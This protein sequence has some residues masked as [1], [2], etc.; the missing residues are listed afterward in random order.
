MDRTD[1]LILNTLQNNC[2]STTKSLAR[3]LGLTA[4]T[5]SERIRRLEEQG[6]IRAYSIDVD[7]EQLG[8][9]LAGFIRVALEPK[10]L[11]PF[12]ELC[13]RSPSITCHYHT[14]GKYNALLR[15]AL[16]N[17]QELDALLSSI[18]RYG[19]S[20]TFMELNVYFQ[21]KDIPLSNVEPR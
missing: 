8:Y 16:R 2:R 14:T 20:Q 3:R 1:R 10:N 9:P 21:C 13:L 5:V 4:P 6:A 11:A 17:I 12:R 15:F 7:R 18:K 19:D